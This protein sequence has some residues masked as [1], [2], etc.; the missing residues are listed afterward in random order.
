MHL[1]IEGCKRSGAEVGNRIRSVLYN[2]KFRK[3]EMSQ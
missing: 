3:D 2:W 1:S